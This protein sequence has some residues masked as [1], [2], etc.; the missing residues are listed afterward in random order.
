MGLMD[1]LNGMQ[2]GPRGQTQPAPAGG[3]HGMSPIMTA[4][5]ALLAYKAIKGGGLGNMLGG[6]QPSVQNPNGNAD[7]DSSGGLGGLLGGLF[8]GQSTSAS[9]GG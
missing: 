6:N 5:L 3:S 2:N 4:L 9:S 8:G 1:I 7:A